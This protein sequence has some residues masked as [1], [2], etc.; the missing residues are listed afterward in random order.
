MSNIIIEIPQGLSDTH[1][2][3]LADYLLERSLAFTLHDEF[4]W[5]RLARAIATDISN[6][7][8]LYGEPTTNKDRGKSNE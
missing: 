2:E 8:E 1:T 3:L 7:V 5:R 4:Q 6:Y